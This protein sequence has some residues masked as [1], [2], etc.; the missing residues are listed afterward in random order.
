MRARVFINSQSQYLVPLAWRDATAA[1]KINPKLV[2]AYTV[3]GLV[4]RLENNF[5]AALIE[6]NKGVAINPNDE[7]ALLNRGFTN[8]S[9]G[10]K[11]AGFRDLSRIIELAPENGGYYASRAGAYNTDG[12]TAK[13]IADYKQASKLNP[14]YG[15]QNSDIELI[16][17]YDKTGEKALADA[18][19]REYYYQ[20]RYWITNKLIPNYETIANRNPALV[21]EIEAD[22]TQQNKNVAEK[23]RAREAEKTAAA[24]NAY[25]N[26]IDSFNRSMAYYNSKVDQG[27][28]QTTRTAQDIVNDWNG[29]KKSKA[30]TDMRS[31]LEELLR[32]H[33]LYLPPSMKSQV[34]ATLKGLN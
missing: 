33:G 11:E 5:P 27:N 25:N 28:R 29:Y 17:L 23:E 19:H 10:N 21:A 15:D 32:V 1:L 31:I 13:A 22:F 14:R 4:L 34:E 12:Q 16:K 9:L 18:T 3:R 20:F 7:K 2:S 8:I 24:I 30:L 26:A 6:I